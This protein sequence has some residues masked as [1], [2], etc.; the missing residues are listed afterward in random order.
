[1][2]LHESEAKRMSVS[3]KDIIR[4]SLGYIAGLLPKRLYQSMLSL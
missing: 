1:M 4:M 3:N 2:L